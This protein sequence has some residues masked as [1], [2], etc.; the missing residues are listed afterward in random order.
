[1]EVEAVRALDAVSGRHGVRIENADE[2]SVTLELK[3]NNGS[4]GG[5]DAPSSVWSC[6]EWD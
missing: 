6:R 5:V 1:M 2:G 4:R 3:L